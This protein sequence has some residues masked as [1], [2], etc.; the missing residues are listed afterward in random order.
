M[1]TF[2]Q[3]PALVVVLAG[4]AGFA[5]EFMRGVQSPPVDVVLTGAIKETRYCRGVDGEVDTLLLGLAVTLENKGSSPVVLMKAAIVVRTV[6]AYTGATTAPGATLSDAEPH[7]IYSGD[8]GRPNEADLL[9]IPAG[10]RATLPTLTRAAIPY[11]RAGL[12]IPGH[13]NAGGSYSAR[14]TLSAWPYRRRIGAEWTKRLSNRGVSVRP[15][16]PC[17]VADCDRSRAAS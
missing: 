10:G 5:A 2:G 11:A 6:I 14:L 7:Y 15:L 3:I 17:A 16:H 12:N 9:F 1:P 4:L 13:P 8:I